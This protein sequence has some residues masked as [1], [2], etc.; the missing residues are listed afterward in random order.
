MK[1]F[2]IEEV[3]R[4]SQSNDLTAAR[5]SFGIP[6]RV[7]DMDVNQS[8]EVVVRITAPAAM[9]VG[10]LEETILAKAVAHMKKALDAA[11]G[12]TARELRDGYP[13]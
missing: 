3:R 10:E 4:Y 6:D 11:E 8:V 12:K 1:T 9:T 5:V 7:S 13:D 2:R